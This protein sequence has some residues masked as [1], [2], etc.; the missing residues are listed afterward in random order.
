MD[1]PT[2]FLVE[3]HCDNGKLFKQY[4]EW[5]GFR[6]ICVHQGSEVMSKLNQIRPS[7]ILMDILMPEQ[8]GLDIVKELKQHPEFHHIPVVAFSALSSADDIEKALAAGCDGYITK[9]VR[10]PELVS[11]IK[12]FVR[13]PED[14]SS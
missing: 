5:E 9:P 6:T 11:R 8:N 12:E 3:D 7:L 1:S 10:L 14:S 4:L 2:I 13:I